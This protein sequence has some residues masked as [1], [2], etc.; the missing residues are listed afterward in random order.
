MVS[1]IRHGRAW[2]ALDPGLAS[3]LESRPRAGKALV[4]EQ[5]AE[6]KQQLATGLSSRKVAEKFGV[7]ASTIQAISQGRTWADIEPAS[8]TPDEPER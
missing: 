5:V 6:I 8:E 2:S 3:R 7:S 4:A 1:A